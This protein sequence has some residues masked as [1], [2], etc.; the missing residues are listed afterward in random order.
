MDQQ[1]PEPLL[2]RKQLA[3]HFGVSI[4]HWS[5]WVKENSFPE[6]DFET[7]TGTKRW[8]LGLVT[9]WQRAQRP[10]VKAEEPARKKSP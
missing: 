3:A 8:S 2:S 5:R 10:V 6:N 4:R 9:L 7:R 1:K